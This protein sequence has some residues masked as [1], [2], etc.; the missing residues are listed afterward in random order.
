MLVLFLIIIIIIIY[1]VMCCVIRTNL[2]CIVEA[3]VDLDVVGIG[4]DATGRR[5]RN[6]QAVT[7]KVCLHRP[8]T[9]FA[10][11]SVKRITPSGQC[12]DVPVLLHLYNV[13]LQHRVHYLD[14]WITRTSS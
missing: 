1:C 11:G 7:H 4:S 10:G 8:G 3:I 6:E 2:L 5:R 14:V 13:Y 12:G 9:I